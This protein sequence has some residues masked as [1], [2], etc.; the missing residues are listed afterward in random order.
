MS[1][2]E[3]LEARRDALRAQVDA[4][5]ARLDDAGRAERA[6]LATA[7]EELGALLD[8]VSQR[9]QR[10]ELLEER[11][12]QLQTDLAAAREHLRQLERRRR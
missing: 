10:V 6:R 12:E 8:E 2:H 5:R 4:L 11:N 1:E 9:E 3:A 7:E